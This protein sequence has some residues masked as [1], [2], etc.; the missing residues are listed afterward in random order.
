MLQVPAAT[1]AAIVAGPQTFPVAYTSLGGAVS[2][3]AYVRSQL[4]AQFATLINAGCMATFASVVAFNIAPAGASTLDPLTATLQQL[5]TAPALSSAHFC[6][7]GSLL[8]LIGNPQLIPPDAAAGTPA[9][10]TLHVL[11]WLATVPLNTGAHVQLV[12]ANVLDEAY[13]LLDPMYAYALRIPFTAAGPQA[14]LDVIE[15][16]ATMMQTPIAR[17]NLAL[18]DPAGTASVPQ[19]L[20]IL[21]SGAVGPE[22]ID[23]DSPSGSY[24][25]DATIARALDNMS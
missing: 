19:M 2:A 6:K 3:D 21:I 8:A 25:W 11:S 18:L 14:S 5:L 7:L 1:I 22:Y 23:L 13:L 24:I 10:P 16:A 12:I 9:K 4:G 17:D 20:Q 15:N